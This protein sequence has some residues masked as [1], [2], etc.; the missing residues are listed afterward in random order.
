MILFQRIRGRDYALRQHSFDLQLQVNPAKLGA[1][2]NAE[3]NMRN[4]IRICQRVVDHVNGTI[5][6]CPLYVFPV[7]VDRRSFLFL[8]LTGNVLKASEPT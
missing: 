4:L 5:N 2:A 3:A 8:L 1:G 7:V 6:K